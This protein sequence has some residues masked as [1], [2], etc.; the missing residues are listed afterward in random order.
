MKLLGK[1]AL[2]LLAVAFALGTIY[3]AGLRAGA[4]WQYFAAQ[5]IS[6]N[7][8]RSKVFTEKSLD[9]ATARIGL[10]LADFPN[11]PD[12]LD[13][14]GKLDELSATQPGVVGLERRELLQSALQYYR[15]ALVARPLWPY[16]WANLLG[17]KDRL[18]AVDEEFSLA[19]SRAAGT[20]PW[21][22]RVQLQV[23]RSGIRY[24]DELGND[25]RLLVEEKL[26][27]ALRV[28]PREAFEIVRFYARPDLVCDKADGK[29]E[30]ERWCNEVL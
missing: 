13:L 10:A 21:E 12:Y 8:H 16:G 3:W 15:R 7:M 22:P 9:E 26:A 20:G 23:I 19:M 27:D 4:A 6:E 11:N 5:T 17:V 14:A 18:G 29:P 1:K 25:E 2:A 24:W 30:I 28:Q